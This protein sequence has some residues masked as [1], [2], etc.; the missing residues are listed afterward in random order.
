MAGRSHV[1]RLS[2]ALGKRIDRPSQQVTPSKAGRGTICAVLLLLPPNSDA[3]VAIYIGIGLT[4]CVLALIGWVLLRRR[5]RAQL[6]GETLLNAIIE[7]QSPGGR[8][9]LSRR[10]PDARLSAAG[11]P[12][13]SVLE[14]HLCNAILDASARERLVKDA[15]TAGVDRAAAIRK[16]LRDLEEEDERWS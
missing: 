7:R 16:V 9:H 4:A 12:Q 14:G 3:I 13:L 2:A 10:S 5:A 11:G 6:S 1:R 8:Q 15:M